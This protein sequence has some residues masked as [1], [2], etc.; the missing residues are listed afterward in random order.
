MKAR[1]HAYDVEVDWTGA[2]SGPTKTYDGYSRAH[3]L[4]IDGKAT[5]ASS[6]DPAFRGDSA[7]H[8]PEQLLV[9]ALASCHLLSY[10]ALCAREGIAVVA[11]CD[12]A[13]G[14]MIE[15]AGVGRFT[16]VTLRPHVA[17]DDDRS[18]RARALH[19]AAHEQCFI[20]NS[21]N[22]PVLCEPTIVRVK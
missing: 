2:A 6:A 8:N 4:R 3:E 5:I 11:Y 15:R 18:D 16:N 22:F 14:T 20:A 10:L 12:R 17:I 21:V 9:A 7:L 1:E 13:T 19:A